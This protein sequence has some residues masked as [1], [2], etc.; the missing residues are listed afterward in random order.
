MAEDQERENMWFLLLAV[1]GFAASR[2]AYAAPVDNKAPILPAPK[3][4]VDAIPVTTRIHTVD[5]LARTAWGEARGEGAQGM[6][7]V[8]NVIMNRFRISQGRTF[9]V[10]WGKSIVDICWKRQ[11]R[12]YQ[13][14]CWNPA[15]PNFNQLRNV[16]I[17]DPQFR[18]AVQ[19]ADQAWRG[20]LP[21]ITRGA[22][23]YHTKA[24]RPAWANVLPVTVALGEHIFYF[25]K[26]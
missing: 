26:V 22:T 19:L 11:G 6:Q 14:T 17:T 9:G 3:L 5:I 18:V 1:A 23:H 10:W 20:N 15:D 12:A 7:A 25:E 21:D 8:I 13:F 4:D 2:P 16:Q 24:V